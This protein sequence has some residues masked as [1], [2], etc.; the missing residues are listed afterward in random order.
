MLI[1]RLLLILDQKLHLSVP[2]LHLYCALEITLPSSA[3]YVKIPF[4]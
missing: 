4:I 3:V 2:Q 1:S